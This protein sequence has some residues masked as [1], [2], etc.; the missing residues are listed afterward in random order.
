RANLRAAIP[1]ARLLHEIC[2]E[3]GLPSFPKT[4]GQSGMHVFVSLGVGTTPAAS[5]TLADLLGRML[6]EA[7]PKLATMERVV[8]R[9]GERSYVDTVQTGASRTIVA[10]WSVRATT[11]AR[12]STPLTWDEVTEDLDPG[13]YTIRTVLDRVR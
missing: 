7:H 6:V 11:G 2:D 3:I 8:T 13:R 5:R 1:L 4:S 9:R 12:V 10:P